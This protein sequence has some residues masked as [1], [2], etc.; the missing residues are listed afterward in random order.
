M[1]TLHPFLLVLV[2]LLGSFAK[3]DL[4]KKSFVFPVA[5]NSANV[6]LKDTPKQP[7]TSLTLCLTYDTDLTRTYSLFSWASKKN[8]N[9]FLLYKPKPNQYRLYIGGD[10]VIFS[11]PE[12]QS[13]RPGGER[14]CVSWESATGI[15]EFWLDGIP[16]PR[17]GLKKGYS[18]SPEASILLGQE[19]DSFGG[20]F[21]VNQ[22]FVGEI[23]D[24]YMWDRVL[25][26]NEVGQIRNDHIASN[27]LINWKSLDY[28][29]KDYVVVKPSLFLWYSANSTY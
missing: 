25:T 6:V 2:G 28:V 22:S 21:D 12:T 9:E 7:L 15:V 4:Q 13:M 17:K 18:I 24:V 16:L 19:Q 8:D 26:P 23:S 20:S 29:A 11:V 3:E 27:P 10:S 5:S 14:I 1:E